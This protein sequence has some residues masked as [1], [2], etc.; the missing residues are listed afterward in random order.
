MV[1][2]RPQVRSYSLVGAPDGECY[3]I[4]VKRLDDGKGGSL[5]MWRLAQGDRLRISEPQ[6]HFPLDWDAP[7]CLFVAGGIGVTPL[8]GMAQAL[9]A[10]RDTRPRMVYGVRSVDELAYAP[11]LK[12]G[13]G[14]RI[15][16]AGG[17]TGR[18]CR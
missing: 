9:L 1:H 2:G 18:L 12:P 16:H 6:N 14:R 13:T 7:A 15:G 5:A 10:A 11:E 8:V 3:R 4:A 17:P